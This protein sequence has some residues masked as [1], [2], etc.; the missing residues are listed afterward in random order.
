MLSLECSVIMTSKNRVKCGKK[1]CHSNSI[2]LISSLLHK[3]VCFVKKGQ[4]R[5]RQCNRVC[6]T[7]TGSLIMC[8]VSLIVSGTACVIHKP[9]SPSCLQTTTAIIVRL[10]VL[11]S[12]NLCPPQYCIFVRPWQ[13][14]CVCVCIRHF[15]VMSRN[16]V[17]IYV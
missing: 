4:K 12:K 16:P 5:L 17:H 13:N 9:I 2:N 14:E 11:I 8:I 7:Y 3:C 6:N 1:A 10:S 15:T